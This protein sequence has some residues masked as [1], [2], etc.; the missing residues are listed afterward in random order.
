M[1]TRTS[2]HLKWLLTEHAALAGREEQLRER[3]DALQ[4]ELA[5]VAARKGALQASAKL[6]DELCDLDAVSPVAA[7]QGKYG[8]RGALRDFMLELLRRAYPAAVTTTAVCDAVLVR[9]DLGLLTTKE[10]KHYQDGTIRPQL[11]AFKEQG[12]VT[13]EGQV[14]LGGGR[15]T[16][17][18]LKTAL[19]SVT[20][21][22]AQAS[23]PGT[24]GSPKG[25]VRWR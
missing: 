19:P 5:E 8:S 2:P 23:A 1:R 21:M 16:S 12:L 3:I 4:A 25:G 10:R 6:F 15:S 22:R 17:W 20:E 7:W 24:G 9:F 14:R 13:C 11:R 18:R